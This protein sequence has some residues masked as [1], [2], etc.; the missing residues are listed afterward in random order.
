MD[1]R[2]ED[3]TGV[4]AEAAVPAAVAPSDANATAEVAVQENNAVI[5]VFAEEAAALV[6]AITLAMGDRQPTV[7]Q[8][9]QKELDL[10]GAR[11]KELQQGMS[12]IDQVRMYSVLRNHTLL[13]SNARRRKKAAAEEVQRQAELLEMA[14]L[15]TR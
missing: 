11:I 1:A 7:L 14:G 12:P 10:M 8:D 9:M 13:G 4:H 5:E 6:E 15:R 2:E 3:E